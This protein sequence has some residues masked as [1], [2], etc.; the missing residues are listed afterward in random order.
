MTVRVPSLLLATLLA[1]ACAGPQ[2]VTPPSPSPAATTPTQTAAARRDTTAGPITWTIDTSSKATIRVRETLVRVQAPSDAVLTVSGA[3]GTFTLNADGTFAS[4]SKISVDMNTIT[5]DERDR[6]STIKR[7]P[8]EVSRFPRAE[9]APTR[10]SGLTLPLA[11]SGD[12]TFTLTG[13]MTIHGVTKTVTF[14]VKATRTGTRLVATATA[15]PAWTFGDFGMR[16]PT[17]FNVVSLVDEIRLEFSLVAN[18][19]VR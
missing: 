2:T 3:T 17:S 7:S 8:L 14:D 13:D 18:E 12:L 16:V 9:L 4:G 15:N 10:A 5:S 6:D 19:T 11:A 1:T